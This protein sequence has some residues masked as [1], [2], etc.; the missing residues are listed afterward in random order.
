MGK[1]KLSIRNFNLNLTGSVEP[2]DYC[3]LFSERTRD[4]FAVWNTEQKLLFVNNQFEELF[5]RKKADIGNNPFSVIEWIHPA[6]KDRILEYHQ[7]EEY[8]QSAIIELEFRIVRPDNS[9]KWIWYRRLIIPDKKGDPYLFLAIISDIHHRKLAEIQ[10]QDSEKMVQMILDHIPVR[11]FWKDKNLNFLGGNQLFLRDSKLNSIDELL[12]KNDFQMVWKALAESYRADDLKVMETNAPKLNFIEEQVFENGS[13]TLVRVSKIPLHD[14]DGNVV[15]VLGTYDDITQKL[16][17]EKQLLL[18]KLSLDNNLDSIFWFN[19]QG[20]IIY[21]NPS[22]WNSLGYTQEEFMQKKVYEHFDNNIT[23]KTWPRFWN[24]LQEVKTTSIGQY[25]VRKDSTRFPVELKANYF[26]YQGEEYVFAYVTDISEKKFIEESVIYRREFER[27]IFNISARFIDIRPEEVDNYINKA[28]VDICEFS[29]NDSAHIYILDNEN[30][31]FRLVHHHSLSKSA[32]LNEIRLIPVETGHWHYLQLQQRKTIQ[33]NSVDALSEGDIFRKLCKT[34]GLQSFIDVSLYYQGELIGFFG[35]ASK[36]ND[37]DWHNDEIN[38]LQ[39]IGDIFINSVQRKLFVKKLQVSEQTYREIYNASAS[40]IL[41]IDPVTAKILDANQP[42]QDL[43]GIAVDEILNTQL[44]DI[45]NQISDTAHEK[46]MELLRKALDAPQQFE[47]FITAKSGKNFWAEIV[48]KKA[49]IHGEK[50]VMGVIR[51]IDERKKTQ[52]RLLESEEQFRSIVQNLSDLVFLLDENA[53]IKFVTPSCKHYL[54]LSVTELAGTS[55][56]NLIHQEDRWLAERNMDEMVKGIE[57]SPTYELRIRHTN[58][59]WKIVECKS[60][61]MLN[62]PAVRGIIYTI[63]DITERRQMEKQILDAI[64]KTEEK[65]RER[66]AKDLHDDLGPLLSSIKMYVGMLDKT[67]D[68]ARQNF[69]VKNLN[70]IVKEAISTTKEVSNDLNPHVLNNY[71]LISALELFIEKVSSEI[72]IVL[73]E[74]IENTRF[75]PA[76]ELSLYRITKELINNTIK[77]AGAKNIKIRIIVKDSRLSLFYDD[78]GKGLSDSN[79]KVKKPGGMGLSNMMSRAKSLN[80]SYNFHTN[81]PEGFKFDLHVPL[82]Q[83]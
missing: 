39:V 22:S 68:K 72:H 42:V 51:N 41:I 34:N 25:H 5:L 29:G 48:M 36:Q 66:F 46:S 62:Q 73:E 70:D 16:E 65:E 59:S 45:F 67:E 3:R 23:A 43:F 18:T 1:K 82:I 53:G 76:I 47:W 2:I 30:Q 54:G 12:G 81:L 33:V 27:L 80:A 28:L 8:R 32:N 24:S 19:H 9:F 60:Q 15:G 74:N 83:D 35:L 4:I 63:S 13:K 57:S 26:S 75:S 44:T 71:G 20:D 17:I 6:D 14:T 11:V 31:C 52:Q 61:G 10:L 58:G 79:L 77:H 21:A 37:K 64:I 49:T 40:S 55:F 7:S 78:D 56:Y 69:I 38:L 50:R